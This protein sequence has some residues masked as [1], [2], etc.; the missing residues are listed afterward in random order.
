M[1]GVLMAFPVISRD[2]E[3]TYKGQTL[4]YTVLDEDAKTVMTAEGYYYNYYYPGNSVSGDL[5][6]PAKVSD[7][8]AIF[9]VTSIGS[10]AF[11]G[12][13]S[14]SIP[15]SVTSIGDY[16]FLRCSGLTSVTIPESVTRIGGC[17]FYECSGL[18]SLTIPE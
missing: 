3:Y 13:T 17:A 9:T 16:A 1:L 6:I 2:F 10:Y 18:T 5:E 15:E 11:S 7:G 12:L 4:R 8:N 14:V